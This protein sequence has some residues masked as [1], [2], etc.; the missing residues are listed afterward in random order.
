MNSATPPPFRVR[1]LDR[2]ICYPGICT[3]QSASVQKR[4]IDDIQRDNRK[5]FS[6]D[7]KNL[8]YIA[9]S[10]EEITALVNGLK[11]YCKNGAGY[12][13]FFTLPLL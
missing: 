11:K 13:Y 1:R 10:D 6:E 3:I 7:L 2:N 9:E 4:V 5:V 8:L 12:S